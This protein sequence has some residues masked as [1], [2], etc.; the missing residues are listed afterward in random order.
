MYQTHLLTHAAP[1]GGGLGLGL[2]GWGWG[3]GAWLFQCLGRGGPPGGKGRGPWEPHG[4]P[5]A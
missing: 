2:G 4:E 3:W 5:M 1:G